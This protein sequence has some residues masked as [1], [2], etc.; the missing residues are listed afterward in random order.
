MTKK[1]ENTERD[2]EIVKVW[3]DPVSRN[4]QIDNEYMTG[5]A[6]MQ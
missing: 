5:K 2:W 4:N 6:S 3:C 1:M